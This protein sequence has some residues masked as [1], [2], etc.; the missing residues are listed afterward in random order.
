[1][2]TRTLLC[3][4]LTLLPYL[5]AAIEFVLPQRTQAGHGRFAGKGWTPRPTGSV[6]KLDLFARRIDDPTSVCGYISGNSGM[7]VESF[8]GSVLTKTRSKPSNMSIK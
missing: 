5:S 3:L 1:M 4:L 2:A 8:T 6:R 7:K